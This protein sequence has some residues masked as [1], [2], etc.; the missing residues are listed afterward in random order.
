MKPS[1]R[2]HRAAGPRLDIDPQIIQ[3]LAREFAT[4]RLDGLRGGMA[5]F[6]AF[7]GRG[8]KIARMH[9]QSWSELYA[10]I[11]RIAY[12]IIDQNIA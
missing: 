8:A 4:E 5:W 11:H 2:P 7:K 1:Y 9:G 3:S 6:N 10:D 12:Q